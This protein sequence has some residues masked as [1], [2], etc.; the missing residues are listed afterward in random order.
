MDLTG[1]LCW[2]YSVETCEV[3]DKE[4]R[5]N[6]LKGEEL[7]TTLKTC[8]E[9]DRS[10]GLWL[11]ADAINSLEKQHV[12]L[13]RDRMYAVVDARCAEGVR[14]VEIQQFWPEDDSVAAFHGKWAT[15]S[16]QWT[17]TMK[18]AVDYKGGSRSFWMS[19][20]EVQHYFTT[21]F[22]AK[23]YRHATFIEGGFS[24]M[25]AGGPIQSET[26]V[27][28]AQYALD[29]HR[30]TDESSVTITVGMHQ[31][32]SRSILTRDVDSVLTYKTS[33]GLSVFLTDDNTRRL[34][35]LSPKEY[36]VHSPIICGRDCFLT[37]TVDPRAHPGCTKLI[38]MPFQTTPM[39][40]LQCFL[41]VWNDSIPTGLSLIQT[42]TR[43]ICEGE[44]RGGTSGGPPLCGTWR[45]NPQ[46]HLYPSEGM[47]VTII[48]RQRND[49]SSTEEYIGF[50]VHRASTIRSILHYSEADVALS[51]NHENGHA[52]AG[53]VRLSGMQE[54]RG[55]PYVI[56]PSCAKAQ[57]ETGFTLEV[58]ANKKVH[59]TKIPAAN[60]WR[61][62][63]FPVSLKYS[64]R[65]TGGSFRFSSWRNNPQYLLH[66]PFEKQGDVLINVT[67]QNVS[68]DTEIGVVLL[69]A[70]PWDHGRRRK[71]SVTAEE[72]LS[73]SGEK[74]HSNE[75]QTSVAVKGTEPLII[76]P[77]ASMPFSEVN[78]TLSIYSAA[79]VE[80]GVV[81]EWYSEVVDGGW[82]LGLTSGGHRSGNRTWS[83]N[84]FYALNLTRSTRLT[85]VLL[86]YPRGPEKPQAKKVGKHRVF[87]PPP[88][89]NPQNKI[90]I[91]MDLV[92]SDEDNTGVQSTRHTYEG[93]VSMSA[94]LQPCTTTPY[95]LVPH[96]FEPE[97]EA[98]F[99]LMVFSDQPFQLYEQK[100]ARRYY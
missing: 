18:Y 41:S 17:A 6:V 9:D 73:D 90:S 83:N 82:E 23:K 10:V 27:E 52:V 42:S 15:N 100:K 80:I 71:I 97:Q 95:L 89:T 46:F 92:L 50:T 28:N 19:F 47:E 13:V 57:V 26:W 2:V 79:D 65:N 54:R 1:G 99:K 51:V 58:I 4:L 64:D 45:N 84:P 77:Y 88:I 30:G 96:S 59:L 62:I 3:D 32:D 91:G 69:K 78:L 43:T 72:I 36:V 53:T 40:P 7:W 48:L 81:N 61:S 14:L 56:V 39:L 68:D 29:L 33:V 24:P 38:L 21:M 63:V 87:L 76:M 75:L 16:P 31:Q 8:R 22:V 98:D 34:A 44:W 93:E 74:V 86:Q 11:A 55:M 60:N 12:G 20:D 5:D 66:L 35:R 70:D 85:A 94:V 37:L 49:L 67:N 25:H